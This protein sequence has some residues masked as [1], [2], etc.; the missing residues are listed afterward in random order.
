[1]STPPAASQPHLE[2]VLTP[3]QAR[4]EDTLRRIL[5]AAESLI[6]EK[7]LADAS[8]PEIV[9]RAGSSVGGFYARL[10]DKNALLRALEERFFADLSERLEEL[11]DAQRWRAASLPGIVA[12]CVEELVSVTRRR[13]NLIQAFLFRASQDPE[14]QHAALRFRDRVSNRIG[15]LLLR[16]RDEFR[17]PDPL[18]AIDLAVQLAFGLMFQL[19]LTGELRAGGRVLSDPELKKELQV[20]F[21][22]YLASDGHPKNPSATPRSHP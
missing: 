1:V 22:R 14:F 12:A 16:R 13:R 2:S 8:I 17:H 11:A 5:E 20:S 15:E 10:P 6:E 9:R 21:L 18:V 4:S 19:V 3:K 7:G